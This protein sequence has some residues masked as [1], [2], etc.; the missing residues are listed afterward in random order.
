MAER[1]AFLVTNVVSTWFYV[2]GS[3]EGGNFAQIR[4]DSASENFRDIYR[5]CIAVF[6]ATARRANPDAQ[7]VLYL[8]R[9]WGISNTNVATEVGLILGNLNVELRV[10]PYLHEPPASFT[11][12]WRNQFFVIDVLRDLTK[13][14]EPSD[15]MVILDSDIVWTT[16]LRAQSFWK[17]L[18][19][20]GLATYEVGYPN[21]KPVNGLSIDDLSRFL[22]SLRTAHSAR[23]S[24]CGGEI[25]GANGSCIQKLSQQ[26]ED[27]W[28]QLMALHDKDHLLA[29]E[30]AH[31]LSLAYASLG[32]EPGNCN[33][34]I[35][36]LWTQPLKP[37]N[38][39]ADDLS[40][41]MW[42]TPAEKKY[43]FARVY[44][45]LIEN[46]LHEFLSASDDDFI[47]R[48]SGHLGIPKN[49][50]LK[51][52]CDILL[53]GHMRVRDLL[54]TLVA[55][56]VLS[57]QRSATKSSHTDEKRTHEG[58]KNYQSE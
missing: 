45:H 29:F 15:N 23:I 58:S 14:L 53:A 44:R 50:L 40:L 24:Y 1:L 9:P 3:E 19:V 42:H 5:R 26:A 10:I 51:V 34:H 39:G 8:N 37:R 54:K 13:R 11:A 56:N 22:K 6:F 57:K 52:F 55:S 4:E 43:G 20:N 33:G 16:K 2:Q 21:A 48:M 31:V 17:S 25:V 35:R 47:R 30:E 18:S 28:A 12:S 36:R 7:L 49:S 38:V 41:T 46:D 27:I 32:H